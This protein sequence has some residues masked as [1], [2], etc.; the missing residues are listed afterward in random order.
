MFSFLATFDGGCSSR[1]QAGAVML[2]FSTDLSV[3]KD[4]KTVGLYITAS[5]KVIHFGEYP[6][7]EDESG[8]FLV[9]FP[10]T[11]AIVSNGNTSG[12]V[13]SQ[14]VAYRENSKGGTIPFVLKE[15]IT[16]V[17]TDRTVLLRM[18]LQW[19]NK[20]GISNANVGTVGPSNQ[21]DATLRTQS[22]TPS[23]LPQSECPQGQT[24]LDG[25][26]GPIAVNAESLPTFREADVFGGGTSDGKGGTCFDVPSCFTKAY[27][28]VTEERSD[29][30][31]WVSGTA[32]DV[33]S[34]NLALETTNNEGICLGGAGDSAPCYAVLDGRP[35][36]SPV[37]AFAPT[38][39]VEGGQ[40]RLPRGVC[41]RIK[42]GA[43]TR[44]VG[45]ATCAAKTETAPSCAS[46]ALTDPIKRVQGTPG[47]DL[48][49][50]I[51]DG[52]VVADA[53]SDAAD[54]SLE[55]L[56]AG[57]ALDGDT[58]D[59]G[60]TVDAGADAGTDAGADAGVDSGFDAGFDSGF[61]AGFDAGPPAPAN[62]GPGERSPQALSIVGTKLYIASANGKV[63]WVDKNGGP[64]A[65][66]SVVQGSI[67]GT[68]DFGWHLAAGTVAGNDYLAVSSRGSNG[69]PYSGTVT[70]FQ[71]LGGPKPI[72]VKAN[73]ANAFAGYKD[74]QFA[75]VAFNGQA[76]FSG[77][78]ARDITNLQGNQ[79]WRLPL[80]NIGT[81]NL[82]DTPFA[83]A[84]ENPFFYTV[85]ADPITHDV[86]FAG[87]DG[88]QPA[89]W[90]CTAAQCSGTSYQL[91]PG[92]LVTNLPFSVLANLAVSEFDNYVYYNVLNNTV[93]TER[94][95]YR[96]LK[97]GGAPVLLTPPAGVDFA[98]P[99]VLTDQYND[100]A[101]D[102]SF[103]YYTTKSAV[104][105]IR[106]T[107]SK[108][109]TAPFALVTGEPGPRAIIQDGGFVY[110][111]NVGAGPGAG[112][113]QVRRIEK[114]AVLP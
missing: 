73:L 2:G 69:P 37:D 9:R 97:T 28:I 76:F 77:G 83:T 109:F 114:P 40:I 87:Y 78:P 47:L 56:D 102:A 30:S 20:G 75:N 98:A 18:P 33:A 51:T 3:P 32:K 93:A 65:T 108:A 110:Y 62:V 68:P 4:V 79:L 42:E 63:T 84:V 71:N 26:C 31:C 100:L 82:M 85:A 57:N 23:I 11:F 58:K 80:A 90:R 15:S 38:W 66:A 17:P 104:W 74:G 13:R 54:G 10:S 111:A 106:L 53:G 99:V 29:G 50:P 52:T 81:S 12:P 49:S 21:A 25:D 88:A 92:N 43:A 8:K 48:G 19:I 45:T 103:M 94:Q 44:L 86:F 36:P 39:R 22:F 5:G 41:K 105:A 16:T 112:P 46:W 7:V 64:G 59:S 60:N 61:D 72:T 101:V 35:G 34:L 91:A 55:D 113:G 70:V 107:G 89:L 96:V 6:A 67:G 14:I 27:P 24:L 1:K 95:V